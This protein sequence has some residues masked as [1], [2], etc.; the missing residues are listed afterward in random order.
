[1][2]KTKRPLKNIIYF[3]KQ[4]KKYADL[5]YQYGGKMRASAATL[6]SKKPDATICSNSIIAL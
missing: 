2:G 3:F 6:K 4:F 1:M 5:M